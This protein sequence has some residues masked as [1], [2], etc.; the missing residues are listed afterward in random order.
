M[1]LIAATCLLY[2]SSA[3]GQASTAGVAGFPNQPNNVGID[4]LGWDITVNNPLIIKNEA[5]HPIRFYTNAGN[6][7]T[8]NNQRMI[9]DQ[10]PGH[11]GIGWNHSPGD[12]VL[13]IL[14]DVPNT[15]YGINHVTVL[16]NSGSQNIFA[17]ENAGRNIGTGFSNSFFGMDAGVQNMRMGANTYIGWCA[18]R[19]FDRAENTFVGSR[20]GENNQGQANT[21]MGVLSGTNNEGEAN[22][23][24]GTSTGN[25]NTGNGNTF[26]GH[27]SGTNFSRGDFN[28]FSGFET[29]LNSAGNQN[30]YSG[31]QAGMIN[32][33][34]F[35]VFIGSQSGINKTSG[36]ENTFVGF[37]TGNSIIYGTLNTFLGANSGSGLAT[38]LNN[39]SA[40]GANATVLNDNSM[41]LGD[42]HINVG[43]G[44]SGVAGGPLRKLHIQDDSIPQL[45]L[46]FKYDPQVN[47]GIWTDFQTTS[48]GDLYIHPVS[49]VGGA[50]SAL[51]RF[52]G[53][54]TSAPQNTL[55]IN[56]SPGI[57]PTPSG[58]RFTNLKSNS[59]NDITPNGRVLT[60]DLFG[61]VV[62][63]DDLGGVNST[64]ATA[65]I[66]ARFDNTGNLLQCS[67]IYNN[68]A[69]PNNRIGLFTT[70]PRLKFQCESTAFFTINHVTPATA[71]YGLYHPN[72]AVI[73]DS[74]NNEALSILHSGSSGNKD[75]FRIYG[76]DNTQYHLRIKGT[77]TGSAISN[78]VTFDHEDNG[79]NVSSWMAYNALQHI[80]LF[81][82][83]FNTNPVPNTN[84]G[85]NYLNASAA[86]SK[87]YVEAQTP[88]GYINNNMNFG[89]TAGNTNTQVNTTVYAGI[90]G[91]CNGSRGAGAA[92]IGGM[93]YAKGAHTKNYAV[94]GIASSLDSTG[95]G[96]ENVAGYFLTNIYGKNNRGVYCESIGGFATN[97]GIYAKVNSSI[98]QNTP[99]GQPPMC[100][101]AAGF[102]NGAVYT[103]E[104]YYQ[105]SDSTLKQNITAVYQTDTLLKNISVYSFTYDTLNAYD[106]NLEKGTHYGLISQQVQQ[107]FPSMVKSF[108]QPE[109]YDSS[110]N[111]IIQQKNILA[112]NY[113]EFIPLLIA[114]YKH[115]STINDSLRQN[116]HTLQSRLDSLI[117]AVANCCNAP[118]LNQNPNGNEKSIELE[119]TPPAI[120]LNQ[121]DPNP[122]AE[123]TTITWSIPPQ[124]N[125]TFN[126][127]LV[128][129]N[130]DGSILKTVKINETGN[131]TLL[132]YGSKLS[133]GIYSYSLVV[134]G[135]TIETKR[136]MKLK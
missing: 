105:T 23:F 31:Y 117:I 109:Q 67:D 116:I 36:G 129:Y 18:G 118:M 89:L 22:T 132:V 62:I 74:K 81:K 98:C 87:V 17:G 16:H 136:M 7:V 2:L 43:I 52:V 20:S 66:V 82:D 83:D 112:L 38:M 56:S 121:N 130:T 54:N 5:D 111:V 85:F 25:V 47:I 128:F 80:T 34:D 32:E 78:S 6:G 55:E 72:S 76:D 1:L 107:V 46:S 28:V 40:L 125:Q 104:D 49:N 13:D 41:I 45:R 99:N 70:D 39:A 53:I 102:F 73:I 97:Y 131:G 29:G 135:K 77:T 127:M 86:S 64:C 91:Y 3:N 51:G 65:D 10:E 35:N 68:A 63:T 119:N 42:N 115:Q 9:I 44:L 59:P 57:S 12:D 61:N 75:L 50:G 134:N 103:T 90:L 122:F 108:I 71:N 95:G 21:F 133:S 124:G 14:P 11:V 126:A 8:P 110:G 92:N 19:N 101:S 48:K 79:T 114:G 15:G 60:V 106:I 4:Y 33:A 94:Q 37:N 84:L 123:N 100:S 120:I 96:V 27:H 26:L 113:S 93:F 69:S 58:L 24:I 88:V 30:V